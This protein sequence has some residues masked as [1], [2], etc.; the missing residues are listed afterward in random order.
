[1]PSDLTKL[2]SFI[3][4]GITGGRFGVKIYNGQVRFPV[5][6]FIFNF[7]YHTIRDI[8]TITS[9]HVY[10]T[11]DIRYIMLKFTIFSETNTIKKKCDISQ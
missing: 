11:S 4:S 1:M 5:G 2:Y 3:R 7:V 8:L 10:T 6:H 9:I